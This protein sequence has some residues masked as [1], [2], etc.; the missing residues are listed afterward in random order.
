MTAALPRPR[1]NDGYRVR[2]VTDAAGL[3]AA[4]R[5]RHDCFITR[6]GLAPRKDGREADAFDARAL[7]VLIEDVATGQPAA[8]YRMLLLPSG[9]ALSRCYAARFYDLTLLAR[10][11]GPL[12]EIGRFCIR[13]GLQ[14]ADLLRLAWGGMARLVAAHDIGFLFGCSSFA[15]TDPARHAPALAALAAG[16]LAP[17]DWAPGRCASET[18]PLPRAGHPADVPD[19]AAA[20]RAMPPLLRS[21][22]AMGG[23]VSDH[24]VIDRTL[25]TLHVFTGVEI[26]AIPPARLRALRQLAEAVTLQGAE[27]ALGAGTGAPGGGGLAVGR[28]AD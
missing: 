17:P 22:L 10:R 28:G 21:Y 2:I 7:H 16:H 6:A 20:Q 11:T 18:V 13:P 15:G 8:T 5:L 19:P 24:A 12:A 26:A 23:R 3:A 27:A 9:A 1:R 4:Q 14:D 25:A